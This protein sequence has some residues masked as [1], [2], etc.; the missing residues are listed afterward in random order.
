MTEERER[1]VQQLA[2]LGHELFDK[3]VQVGDRRFGD[4]AETAGRLDCDHLDRRIDELRPVSIDRGASTGERKAEQPKPGSRSRAH[5]DEPI[6]G[7]PCGLELITIGCGADVL[8]GARA[9]RRSANCR[10]RFGLEQ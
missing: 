3:L 5:N 6:A 10:R 9:Y 1:P 4:T 2:H 7:G 8:V